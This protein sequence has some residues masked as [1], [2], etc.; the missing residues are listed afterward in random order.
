MQ[1]ED[2]LLAI[3]RSLSDFAKQFL[4][5]RTKSGSI[6]PFCFN[7]AQEFLHN[8]LEKQLQETGRV[9][10]IILK[11]R[12][13]G[14]T[15]YVQARFFHKVCTQIGKKAFILT[16]EAEATKNVFD[17]TKRFYELLPDGLVPVPDASSS[18][19]L[20]FKELNSGYSVGTAGNKAV[21]RSQTVQLMHASEVAYYPHAE[22]HAKGILQTVS[23]E[24]G[25]ELILE[26][27]ANGLGNYFYNMWQAA[28]SGESDFIP[29]FLPWY[30]QLEYTLEDRNPDTSKLSDEE[31]EIYSY[32]KD[33][34]LTK[35]H[36]Y[37]RR[38]KLFEFSN[39]YETARE[40]LNVEYPLTAMDAFRNPVADR[41]IKSHLVLKARKNRIETMSP[42][43]IGIDPAIAD[44]DR[45]AIIRRRGRLAYD[46][47]TY[48][49]YKP[50]ELVGLIRKIIDKEQPNKV[51]IDS[52]GIGAGIVD[53][54]LELGY[55]QVEGVCVARS[56]N[57]KDKFKNLRAELWH[58]M[59]E[60]MAQEM[61]VQIPD[62]DELMA[63]LTSLGYKHD[64]SG[65]LQIESKDELRA[66]GIRSPD[67]ADALSL[68]FVMGD[69]LNASN[70]KPNFMP[71][72]AAGM[73][74]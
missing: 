66:R 37:W 10:A 17:M 2:D 72:K 50:M 42:L 1:N 30:W 39:D 45:S 13:G 73:F 26:S 25:T 11:G 15:T 6:N 31:E 55:T 9:R 41:F 24:N 22:E 70:Y 40:L 4:K 56:A 63:D 21:G 44:T 16:H 67:C 29:V 19:N 8:R 43:V 12:Q 27:T 48:Y 69:Y 59:R 3:L 51:L 53:R 46:L 35:E 58:E 32:H 71:K 61:G 57:D 38:K 65:R 7:R 34:G 62:S 33:N 74:I 14:C 18:K 20:N 49:N 52:I 28:V 54:L 64:S 5:I 23:N 36:L 68:T 60:W 47:Q